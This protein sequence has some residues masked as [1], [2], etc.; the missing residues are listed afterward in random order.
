MRP[1][2]RSSVY[3]DEGG[4]GAFLNLEKGDSYETPSQRV[5]RQGSRQ[6][7]PFSSVIYTAL[8]RS[9]D[10]LVLLIEG[11]DS[12]ALFDLSK[13][14]NSE[15][16]VSKNGFQVGKNLFTSTEGPGLDMSQVAKVAQDVRRALEKL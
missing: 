1:F 16:V 13:P 11:N 3:R 10:A 12:T 14:Q 9:R 5:V 15:R 4:N 2:Q 7:Y 6:G 8:T